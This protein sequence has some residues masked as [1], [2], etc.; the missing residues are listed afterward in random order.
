MITTMSILTVVFFSFQT[1]HMCFA[2]VYNMSKRISIILE[3]KNNLI[4]W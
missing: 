1:V 4:V 3:N 2:Y